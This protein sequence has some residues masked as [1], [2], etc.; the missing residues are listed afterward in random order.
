MMVNA[1]IKLPC[2]ALTIGLDMRCFDCVA[3]CTI[4]SIDQEKNEVIVLCDDIE[5]M[6][7]VKDLADFYPDTTENRKMLKAK[8]D[9]KYRKWELAVA[10]QFRDLKGC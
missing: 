2:K 6:F 7:S 4:L 1:D 10:K 3:P 8:C 9:E 5:M